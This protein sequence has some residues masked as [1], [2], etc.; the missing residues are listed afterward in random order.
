MRF[1][2]R[3]LQFLREAKLLEQALDEYRENWS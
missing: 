1:L 3:L 2:K